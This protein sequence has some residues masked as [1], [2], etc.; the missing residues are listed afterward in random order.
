MDV[1]KLRR[2]PDPK[3]W[4][5]GV[6]AG[7]AYSL[8][9]PTWLVRLLFIIIGS[10]LVTPFCIPFVYLVVWVLMPKWDE[11]PADYTEICE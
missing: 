6:C 8:K 9:G 1:N 5:G 7:L 3:A 10:M 4:L 2:I 11:V